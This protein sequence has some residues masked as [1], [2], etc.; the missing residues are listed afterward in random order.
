IGFTPGI[1]TGCWVG[2]D[3]PTNLG[4]N[5]T[6]GNVCGPIWNEYMKVALK[7]QPPVDF[8]AP[9]GM[10][11]Q[12]VPEPDGQMVTEAFKAGQSPG[13]QNANGL[14]GGGMDSLGGSGN[15]GALT[16]PQS[17]SAPGASPP[18]SSIDKSLGGLY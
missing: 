5:E 16:A 2:F 4:E 13:A 11:L 6:G 15:G 7:N 8:T 14:L 1:V 18:P 3:T 17:G 9:A 10:T 12:Q